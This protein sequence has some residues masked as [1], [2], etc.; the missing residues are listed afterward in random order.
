[1]SNKYLHS[2]PFE[3]PKPRTITEQDKYSIESVIIEFY[4]FK[5]V[6][7]QNILVFNFSVVYVKTSYIRSI[8]NLWV[9]D[10]GPSMDKIREIKHFSIIDFTKPTLLFEAH[11]LI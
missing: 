11:F 8:N 7:V 4:I 5:W 6:Y 1:M 2:F 3:T 9:P 10:V